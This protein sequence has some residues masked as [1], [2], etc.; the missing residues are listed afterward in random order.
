MA[1]MVTSGILFAINTTGGGKAKRQFMAV[2]AGMAIA[3]KAAVSFMKDAQSLHQTFIQLSDGHRMEL[4]ELEKL[5]KGI[6]DTGA[7]MKMFAT[8]NKAGMTETGDLMKAMTKIVIDEG[9]KMGKTAEEITQDFV[10]LGVGISK[11]SGRSLKKLGIDLQETEDLLLMQEEALWKVQDRA[12][13][14]TIE[15]KT[16]SEQTFAAKNSWDTYTQLLFGSVTSKGALTNVIEG[17]DDASEAMI[18]AGENTEELKKAQVVGALAGYRWGAQVMGNTALTDAYNEKIEVLIGSMRRLAK[19]NATT[20]KFISGVSLA[21]GGYAETAEVDPFDPFFEEGGTSTDLGA[22]AD[23]GETSKARTKAAAKKDP[24]G[25]GAKAAPALVGAELWQAELDAA[26]RSKQLAFDKHIWLIENNQEYHDEIERQQ[27]AAGTKLGEQI[28]AERK[29]MYTTE[30]SAF[31]LSQEEK[32]A[33]ELEA[34]EQEKLLSVEHH[35]WLML[36]DAY[37]AEQQAEIQADVD[38]KELAALK[39]KN[40]LKYDAAMY[41]ANMISG[42]MKNMSSLMQSENKKQFEV[43]KKFAYASAVMDTARGAASA[44]AG[45]VK[46]YGIPWGLVA[47]LGA[48]ATVAVAGGIQIDTIKKQKF[49]TSGGGVSAGAVGSGGGGYLGGGGNYA[50]GGAGAG[51]VTHN[52]TFILG[53]EE[54]HS[55][56]IAANDKASQKGDPAFAQED[57]A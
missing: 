27:I 4:A 17:L 57:A 44:I 56:V 18:L 52:F 9:Q 54:F 22:I 11:G 7:T 53:E 38:A 41:G 29:E 36:N 8:L 21:G 34:N 25:G 23:L 12:E 2:A 24:S 48:A 40:Q 30:K 28:M 16:L 37:Y 13:G 14:L 20:E 46:A 50:A 10:E 43:G 51:T 1:G 5:N 3:G 31:E 6:I 47:G 26:E 35:E 45:G 32:W 33:V 42:M 49:G 15:L 55:A 39:Q 19:L